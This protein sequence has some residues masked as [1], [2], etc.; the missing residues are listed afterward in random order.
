MSDDVEIACPIPQP[1]D[2]SLVEIIELN[3]QPVLSDYLQAMKLANSIADEKL[4]DYM[5]LSW[6]DRDRDFESPQHSSE[7]HADS[8]VPGYVDY[9]LNHGARLKVDIG[10]GRFV[11]FY[12]PL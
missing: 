10:Q 4:G 1:P 12:L 9:G 3:P 2:Y 5:L 6:Y 8:A 7:C 11:F